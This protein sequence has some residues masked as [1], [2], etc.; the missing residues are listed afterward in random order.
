MELLVSVYDQYQSFEQTQVYAKITEICSTKRASFGENKGMSIVDKSTWQ[1]NWS[2]LTMGMFVG[3]NW[4]NLFV[5]GGAVLGCMLPG[6]F[7][8]S[9]EINE[10]FLSI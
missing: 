7:L 3:M 2:M 1:R 5:A 6:W 4:D 9:M 8:V 10:R